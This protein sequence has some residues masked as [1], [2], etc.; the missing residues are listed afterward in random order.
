MQLS[1]F[2]PKT[3]YKPPVVSELP[4]WR[5]AKRVAFDLE[6]HDPYLKT[7]GPS[8]RRGGYIAGFSFAIDDGPKA[9]VPVRHG[10]G[11]NVENPEQAMRYLRHQAANFDGLLIGANMQYDLDYSMEEGCTWAQV[12]Q[13]RDV[14]VAGPLIN[15]LERS[16]SLDA[17]AKRYGLPGKDETLLRE[18][19]TSFKLD[20]KKDMAKM[21]AR[22]V[23]RYGEEDAVQTLKVMRKQELEIEEHGLWRIFDLESRLLPVLLRMRRRGVLINQARLDEI[24]KWSLREEKAALDEVARRTG[25]QVGV[26]NVWKSGALAEALRRG[27]INVPQKTERGK[28]VYS[29]DKE[30]LGRSG[31]L[32]ALLLRARKVNKLRTTFAQSITDHMVQG[33]VHCTF[34]QLRKTDDVLDEEG[35]AAY[36]RLSCVG[37]NLQQQ[38]ARDEFAPFWRSI[39]LP[40]PGQ[41][42]AAKDY[43]QQEPRWAVH[44]AE[45]MRLPMAFEAAEKYR[46]DPNTDNHQMMADLAGIQRKA[47]KEIY[48]GITYG[49][50]GA[51][52]CRKLGLPTRMV[53]WSRELKTQVDPES[54]AGQRAR[55]EGGRVYEAAGIEGQG[56]ID[57]LNTRVPFLKMLAKRTEKK[58][59]ATGLIITVGGRHC[60]F[61][62]DKDGNFDFCHKALNR[63]IQGSSA[64]QTK[65]A[66]VALS[67]GGFDDNLLLQ[68]HD[69]IDSS[70]DSP[71]QAEE[72]AHLM[73]TCVPCRVPA[74]VDV[75]IGNSWGNSM[76]KSV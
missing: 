52:M 57:T 19:A 34:N 50:G 42:W 10:G 53:V 48:L 27:D 54:E 22:F 14:Q 59:L 51:K 7:L 31:E 62:V 40:E 26:G 13:F 63:L 35:G 3:D 30:V 4:D 56:I 74:K 58:A 11:D 70:V 67:E 21:P 25:Y 5:G 43:S 69:E 32:G 72:M 24:K 28:V 39:Y 2:T 15:E 23:A 68:V 41:L 8:V 38:P 73:R 1:F 47:A 46:T 16:Y 64:D 44:F 75:E 61:P 20:A 12:K 29:V 65:A 9:Y 49:M 60:H 45:V 55:A 17:L 71:E 33:R 66:M 6:T 36:G 76:D 18:A 37:P